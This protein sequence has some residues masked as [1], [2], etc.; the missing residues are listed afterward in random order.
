MKHFDKILAVVLVAVIALLGARALWNDRTCADNDDA[1]ARLVSRH[2]GGQ[3]NGGGVSVIAE[4]DLSGGADTAYTI[5]A[6]EAPEV[7]KVGMAVFRKTEGGKLALED[8]RIW[9]G[10]EP[11]KWMTHVSLYDAEKQEQKTYNIFLVLDETIRSL[12]ETRY[13]S[14][15]EQL[16][17]GRAEGLSPP[18][19]VAFA[20]PE[21][22]FAYHIGDYVYYNAQERPF[23]LRLWS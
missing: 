3:L 20:E 16:P 6:F 19:I 21:P 11:V 17:P 23:V 1:A 22:S 14:A 5:K 7:G 8:C 18:C 2:Y 9:P 10:G 13:I 12:E 4:K 15:Q